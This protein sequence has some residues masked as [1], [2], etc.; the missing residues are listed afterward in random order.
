MCHF[1]FGHDGEKIK[2]FIALVGRLFCK[3][4]DYFINKN[5]VLNI[6][7]KNINYPEIVLFKLFTITNAL[8]V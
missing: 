3:I 5:M 2:E 7:Y 8:N 4:I 1:L 6:L